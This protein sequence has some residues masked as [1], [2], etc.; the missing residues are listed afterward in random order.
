MAC[1]TC[2]WPCGCFSVNLNGATV[3][4]LAAWLL[5]IAPTVR[6]AAPHRGGGPVYRRRRAAD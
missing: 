6:G 2:T 4:A 3:L 5:L 1:A